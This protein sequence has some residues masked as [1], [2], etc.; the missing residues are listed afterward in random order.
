MP[1]RVTQGMLNNQFM[2][3]LSNNM[4]RMDVIQDQLSTGRR[5]NKPSDDPV[6]ITYSLRY[7]SELSANEQYQRNTDAALSWLDQT[8][9]SLNQAGEILQRVRELTVQ[10]SNGTNPPAAMDAIRKEIE[11]LKQQLVD[12]A[13]TTLDGK[14]IFNGQKTDQPPYPS[15]DNAAGAVT[16]PFSIPFEVGLNVEIP[17]N[18]TGNDV[19]GKPTDPDN[20]FQVLDD[21]MAHLAAND[22]GEVSKILGRLDSRMEKFLGFRSEIGARINRIEMMQGRLEDLGINLTSLQSK[23]EDADMSKLITQLKMDESVYQ[24]SLAI[25]SRLIQPSLIDFLR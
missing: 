3:N 8:D 6:G 16:D 9:S 22:H 15:V 20:L 24:A 23:V 19:F 18:L 13:S 12:V 11:Q 14:Y 25:G 4:R 2:R 10:G 1:L 5:I 7:R 21:L 17:V